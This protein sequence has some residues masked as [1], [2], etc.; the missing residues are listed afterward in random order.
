[1]TNLTMYSLRGVA[2]IRGDELERT[3]KLNKY[4]RDS[5]SFFLKNGR[6]S[7]KEIDFDRIVCFTLWLYGCDKLK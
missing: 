7:F 3:V 6:S 1:M 4:C 2:S 5:L